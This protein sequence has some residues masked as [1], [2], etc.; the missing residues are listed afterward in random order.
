MH[1]TTILNRNQIINIMF[2]RNQ[3]LWLKFGFSAIVIYCKFMTH[4]SFRSAG[5][6]RAGASMVYVTPQINAS[7]HEEA[8]HR[9]RYTQGKY[10]ECFRHNFSIS[11]VKHSNSGIPAWDPGTAGRNARVT[12]RKSCL[13]RTYLRS[14]ELLTSTYCFDMNRSLVLQQ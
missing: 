2:L 14:S 10:F 13:I 5:L 3:T 4:T 1:S 11:F 9:V 6:R 7:N 8:I 12:F